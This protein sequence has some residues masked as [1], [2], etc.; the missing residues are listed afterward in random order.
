MSLAAKMDSFLTDGEGQDDRAY[1]SD[2]SS[3]GGFGSVRDEEGEQGVDSSCEGNHSNNESSSPDGDD[4]ESD[5]GS[6]QSEDGSVSD[7]DVSVLSD[8]FEW[9]EDESDDNNDCGKDSDHNDDDYESSPSSSDDAESDGTHHES[10]SDDESNDE[11]TA[12]EDDLQTLTVKQLKQR[13]RKLDLPVGGK[14]ADLIERLLV[15]GTRARHR[16][17]VTHHDILAFGLAHVGFEEERQNV[18]IALN[19]DRFKTHFGPDPRA[20]KDLFLDLE[21]DFEG[22]KYKEVMMALNW[23]KLCKFL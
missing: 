20:I 1:Y 2:S 17:I 13:L 21:E 9:E 7:D 12:A 8:D 15:C 5:N 22:I 18:R 3:D 6:V 14:K 11:D 10:E 19:I 4:D 16:E 23:L